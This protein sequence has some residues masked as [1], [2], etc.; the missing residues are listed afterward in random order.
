MKA[1]L[2]CYTLGDA[3]HDVRS[4]F[5]REFI[6]Y[7]DKSNNGAYEYKREGLLSK[8]SHIKPAKGVIIVKDSD[9]R[10][11]KRLLKKYKAKV[12]SFDINIKQSVFH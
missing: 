12:K 8:I 11:V 6:G 9:S 5:K 3:K 2:I 4:A 1:V 10:K 7:T